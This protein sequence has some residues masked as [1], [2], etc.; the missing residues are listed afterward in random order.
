MTCQRLVELITLEIIYS[1][2][3]RTK[4]CFSSFEDGCLKDCRSCLI[5]DHQPYVEEFCWVFNFSMALKMFM[6]IMNVI[7][8][9]AFNH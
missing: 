6:C 5:L 3:E 4:F 2:Y 1:R 8:F 7:V 9:K